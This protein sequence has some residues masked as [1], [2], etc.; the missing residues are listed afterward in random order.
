MCT[1]LEERSAGNCNV[2]LIR[3]ERF[4]YSHSIKGMCAILHTSLAFHST[5]EETKLSP[6]RHQTQRTNRNY[7]LFVARKKIVW[8][9]K[10]T[11]LNASYA[12]WH[13][14]IF[15]RQ[16]LYTE[17][18]RNEKKNRNFMGPVESEN[19]FTY[20]GCRHKLSRWMLLRWW[21][22]VL[23][24]VQS[25]G[26]IPTFRRDVLPQLQGSWIRFQWIMEWSRTGNGSISQVG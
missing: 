14:P 17:K 12:L 24:T 26:L 6:C 13:R 22:S 2:K 25:Y 20:K 18:K 9:Q 10:A 1:G 4:A 21:I 15:M 8:K 3:K 11:D 5:T 7:L 16:A 23:Y 19:K